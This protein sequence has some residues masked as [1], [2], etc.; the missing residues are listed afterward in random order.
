MPWGGKCFYLETDNL[1]NDVVNVGS[2]PVELI[3]A[4]E[5]FYFGLINFVFHIYLF[6]LFRNL[7][8]FSCIFKNIFMI[9]ERR[10]KV[11][12]RLLLRSRSQQK[13]R[14]KKKRQ[15]ALV[16]HKIMPQHHNMRSDEPFVSSRTDSLCVEE[17]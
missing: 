4:H 8:N 5:C 12:Y 15:L 7:P 6:I 3:H 10:N 17:V 11:F 9:F 16:A 14:S 2:D 1:T 13:E